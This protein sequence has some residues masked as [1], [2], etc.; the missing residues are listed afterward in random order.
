MSTKDTVQAAETGK[1]PGDYSGTRTLNANPP[2]QGRNPEAGRHSIGAPTGDTG[3]IRGGQGPSGSGVGTGVNQKTG[4]PAD[5]PIR[6]MAPRPTAEL[7]T[8]AA[9][10]SKSAEALIS[11]PPTPFR[12]EGGAATLYP[13]SVRWDNAPGCVPYGQAAEP[14]AKTQTYGHAPMSKSEMEAAASVDGMP[15]SKGMN[16]INGGGAPWMRKD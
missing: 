8:D 4:V 9:Q 2:T 3:T 6:S 15:S 16:P 14:D 10:P 1:I 12:A 7:W 5:S 11:G 13:G